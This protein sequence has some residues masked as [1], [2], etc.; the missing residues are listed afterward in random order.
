MNQILEKKTWADW[1]QRYRWRMRIGV[2]L[3]IFATGAVFAWSLM[4]TA[5]TTADQAAANGSGGNAATSDEGSSASDSTEPQWWTCAMHPQIRQQKPGKCPICRMDLVPVQP[6]A[7]G[8]RTLVMRPEVVKLLNIQTT[9]VERRYVTAKIRMV[10]K[11][12][13]DETRLAHITAWV[14][15]RL[16]RL[17]VNYT[18]VR[19]N[20]GDHMVY[21]YSE[22]L[23]SI[24]EELLQALQFQRE[25][26]NAAG[27]LNLVEA[28]REKLRLL[29]LTDQQV[30]EIEQR[31]KADDHVTI[32]APTS[33]IVIEKLR[34]EGD[35][36]NVGDRIYTVA[37]L[38]HLWLRLDAYESDLPWVRYGQ[39]L[40]FTT[41]AYPGEI[42]KGRISFIDP[43]LNKQ[44]RTV[45]V[46]VNV[47]NSHGRLKPEM[48]VHAVVESKVA[49]GGRVLDPELAGK[50]ISPMHPEIV[51][52]EPGVCDICGMPLVRAETLGYV[53]AESDPNAKPLVIPVSAALITGTR[54]IVYVQV[55]GTK[56]PTFEGREVLLGPRAG[57]YYIVRH[58]L[59]EG[60]KVVTHGNFKIDSELQIQAKPTMMIPD[61]GG[62]G[63]HDH[64]GGGSK[65]K[66][67]EGPPAMTMNLPETFVSQVRDMM[68]VA[69]QVEKEL[70][71]ED[72]EAVRLAFQHFRRKL[73][74]ISADKLVD[75]PAMVWREFLMRLSNDAIEGSESPDLDTARRVVASLKHNLSQLR[76]Q[77]MLDHAGHENQ[78]DQ[79]DMTSTKL[80]LPEAFRQQL[81]DLYGAYL[82]MR[83]A[84]AGDDFAAARQAT[85][86][87]L[88]ALNQVSPDSLDGDAKS[89]WDKE[90]RQLVLIGQA[91]ANA[92][93]IE[94]A[95]L[96]FSLLSEQMLAMA[97]RFRPILRHD[98]FELHCP[99]AFDGRG[100]TWLQENDQ[101]GNP[102]YGSKMLSCADKV[103]RID[104]NAGA[105][106]EPGAHSSEDHRHE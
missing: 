85:G 46:R 55:E 51:K 38:S 57:D 66:P 30:A 94:A 12:D 37:D 87:L 78:H 74:L 102:Y 35:R 70:T 50:W 19:V 6:S 100:A 21:M 16:D 58:G 82:E 8:L 73:D 67:G 76:Q 65:K 24:Q 97:R 60:E 52:D 56:Q 40:S 98:L 86:K 88:A 77:L 3:L 54:A 11:L 53:S 33:G 84:L 25:N 36:V 63:G 10:G 14:P 103:E 89:A 23:Y 1:L 90:Q 64:G 49:E 22:E 106:N 42:F 32:Y 71:T 43:V 9:P 34:Q 4:P 62:G 75:H 92:K 104:L 91:L 61:G 20:Q 27:R 105:S 44:T 7:G 41:E 80:E 81:A 93:D 69:E 39:R 28:A 31:G 17:F 29:G 18:G 101:T 72:I 2:G 26:P 13:Y 45:K 96:Q 47:D 83:A 5:S 99:M 95:R 79:M 15:G 59:F 48:F 68:A